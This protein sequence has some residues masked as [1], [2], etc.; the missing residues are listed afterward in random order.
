MQYEIKKNNLQWTNQWSNISV[1]KYIITL[2]W[3]NKMIPWF[4]PDAHKYS[5]EE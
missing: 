3:I 1:S 2:E 4:G 5:I